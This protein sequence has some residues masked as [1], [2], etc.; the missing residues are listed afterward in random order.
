MAARREAI[1][2][3]IFPIFLLC[4]RGVSFLFFL[5]ES[6]DF[7]FFFKPLFDF[8]KKK[9]G[10]HF[11]FRRRQLSRSGGGSAA[12]EYRATGKEKDRQTDRKRL[13]PNAI[14]LFVF[15][16]CRLLKPSVTAAVA[17]FSSLSKKKKKKNSTFS[18]P[19][20]LPRNNRR[21][22]LFSCDAPRRPL[23]SLEAAREAVAA[24]GENTGATAAAE[25]SSGGGGSCGGDDDDKKKS[26][27]VHR[28]KN[29]KKKSAAAASATISGDGV[30]NNSDDN[31]DDKNLS[32]CSSSFS[33]DPDFP[34]APLLQMD[35]P[36]YSYLL[37]HTREPPHLVRL[38]EE[39]AKFAGPRA[40]NAVSPEQ[41][42]FLRFLVATLGAKRA[43]EVGVFTGYSSVAIASALP[44]AAEGGLLLALEKDPRPLVLAKKAWEA[45][46]VEDR[47]RAVVGDAR[48]E[49][50]RL[51]A[52]QEE[53][54][55]A[56]KAEEAAALREGERRAADD[57]DGAAAP[58]S[59][60]S[61]SAPFDFA[62]IDADKRGY[63]DYFESCLKLVRKGGV[64]AID[65]VLWYGRVAE[66][67]EPEGEATTEEEEEETEGGGE[68]ERSETEEEGRAPAESAT[69]EARF[70]GSEEERLSE[71]APDA[72]LR[73]SQERL[74]AKKRERR[75]AASQRAATEAV[76]ELNSRLLEDARIDLS[77][78]PIGDGIAL[79]RKL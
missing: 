19:P 21:F 20:P 1:A 29:D 32:D 25:S 2:G 56:E 23:F 38:R 68:E 46:G 5:R 22:G 65:N 13:L 17:T 52:A 71:A 45:A 57:A 53:A 79:C 73:S 60:S 27:K 34:A 42:N 61:S 59:S 11:Q 66:R 74:R 28:K 35:Q 55:G 9:C 69:L 3:F 63:L 37:R 49:L 62:F 12:Q 8:K 58:S 41:G 33:F 26:K 18:R 24:A 70:P 75:R 78:V 30:N 14:C 64:I 76:R 31:D 43:L 4:F 15:F 40:R 7:S 47:V 48:E 77:I 6:E 51:V 39:T 67:P 10:R 44:P 54:E 72:V 16:E 36:L 50:A